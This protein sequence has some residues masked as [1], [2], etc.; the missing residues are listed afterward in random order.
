M[1]EITKNLSPLIFLNKDGASDKNITDLLSG[2]GSAY[3]DEMI[4]N[5]WKCYVQTGHGNSKELRGG[6]TL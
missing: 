5:R 2:V 4:L 3:G 1:N 6:L